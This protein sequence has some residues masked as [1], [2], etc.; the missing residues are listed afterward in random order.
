MIDIIIPSFKDRTINILLILCIIM[1][2][3]IMIID[4]IMI[5]NMSLR[6]NQRTLPCDSVFGSD[7]KLKNVGDDAWCENKY[8][9]KRT[10]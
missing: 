8:G 6:H 4:Y 7:Y 2:I 5:V 10:L 3:T 9:V 1:T